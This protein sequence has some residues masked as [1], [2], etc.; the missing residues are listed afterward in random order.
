MVSACRLEKEVSKLEK[1]WHADFSLEADRFIAREDIEAV[2]AIWC[3]S[4]FY[5]E[6]ASIFDSNKVCWGTYRTVRE[7]L[8]E[9]S[10]LSTNNE[11]FEN[12]VTEGIGDHLV[13]G[14]PIRLANVERGKTNPAPVLGRTLTKF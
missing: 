9:D 4:R 14:T 7:A 2:V 8:T 5:K 6:I 12:I 3:K 10:R 1:R 13:A 11:I